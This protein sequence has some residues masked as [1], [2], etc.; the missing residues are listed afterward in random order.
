MC[1]FDS[2]TDHL[3]FFSS[4]LAGGKK[5]QQE[6]APPPHPP[7]P[8]PIFFRPKM[9][10]GKRREREKIYLSLLVPPY[11]KSFFPA[12]SFRY[13]DLALVFP[14]LADTERGKK[15][16]T[17]K[18]FRMT[19]ETKLEQLFLGVQWI[20]EGGKGDAAD[21][22]GLLLFLFFRHKRPFLPLSFFSFC[23]TAVYVY[24]NEGGGQFRDRNFIAPSLHTI[25]YTILCYTA[26]LV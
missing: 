8:P 25:F 22:L 24:G 21:F 15:G 11:Q 4:F 2:H 26:V 17:R 18:W 6:K 19:E 5:I 7:P 20:G 16:K 1:V 23:A 13:D 14:L 12:L 3:L 9:S 10:D